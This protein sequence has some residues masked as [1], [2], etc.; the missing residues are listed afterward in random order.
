MQQRILSS[1]T[2]YALNLI[3]AVIKISLSHL[4]FYHGET[5]LIITQSLF[6]GNAC[7]PFHSKLVAPQ[8]ELF[9]CLFCFHLQFL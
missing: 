6:L 3:E 9:L 2:P 8:L 4:Y 5:V 7:L 1:I